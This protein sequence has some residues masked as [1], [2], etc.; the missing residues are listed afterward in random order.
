MFDLFNTSY[1]KLSSHVAISDSQKEYFKK[2][3]ISF[4]NP[5]YIKF[6]FDSNNKLVAF[7]S[8]FTVFC[9]SFTKSQW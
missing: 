5:E 3:F 9:K 4:I 6:I 8:G 2:K 1:A 7:Y